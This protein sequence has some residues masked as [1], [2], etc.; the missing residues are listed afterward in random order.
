MWSDEREFLLSNAVYVPQSIVW[1]N[2]QGPFH[3]KRPSLQGLLTNHGQLHNII[4]VLSNM[5]VGF[6]SRLLLFKTAPSEPI[7]TSP[8]TVLHTNHTAWMWRWYT[9]FQS[10]RPPLPLRQEWIKSILV[11]AQDLCIVAKVGEVSN[12]AQVTQI[13]KGEMAERRSED[14]SSQSL[15]LI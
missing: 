3:P 10:G 12:V 8:D 1:H 15:C 5:T 11:Q 6:N 2:N 13:C 4:T 7:S 14:Q 9:P